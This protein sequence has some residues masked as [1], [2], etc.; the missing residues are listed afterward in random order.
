MK[1]SLSTELLRSGLKSLA[2]IAALIMLYVVID[3]SFNLPPR[4]VYQLRVPALE[5]N[6]PRLL[7]QESLVL[8][9]ARFDQSMLEK[10]MP[11]TRLST[12]SQGVRSK[13]SSVDQQGY[14]VAMGYGTRL[15]CPLKLLENGYQE[16]C[17]DARYDLLGRSLSP[18]DYPDL[19]IPQ[20]TFNHDYS[21]LTIE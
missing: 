6:Q 15:S 5:M 9:V 20:Y 4:P 16:G 21:L 14:F 1:L 17:S 3:F 11:K 18:Q 12:I 7:Q 10:M 2:V 8:V 13:Q 19:E